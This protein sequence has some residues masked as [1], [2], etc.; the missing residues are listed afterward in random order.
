M[1]IPYGHPPA[2]FTV[3]VCVCRGGKPTSAPKPRMKGLDPAQMMRNLQGV[4][5]AREE[6][7]G[8]EEAGDRTSPLQ[9]QVL[10]QVEEG[11]SR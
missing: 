8:E 7:R 1:D 4:A 3:T 2:T 6:M 11:H 10:A 5:V 9:G